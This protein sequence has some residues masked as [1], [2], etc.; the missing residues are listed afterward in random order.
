MK[1]ALVTFF[2]AL[3][4]ASTLS[5]RHICLDPPATTDPATGAPAPA[6][7]VTVS[8]AWTMGCCGGGRKGR[9]SR[10][11]DASVQDC[12]GG[13]HSFIVCCGGLGGTPVKLG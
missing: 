1:F 10:R 6:S 4:A 12:M 9:L 5:D 7:A 3:A 8:Q 13:G 2:A 11:G